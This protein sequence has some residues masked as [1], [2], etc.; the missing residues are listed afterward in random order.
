MIVS[1]TGRKSAALAKRDGS[2][3]EI[4]A[5]IASLS[6]LAE[7]DAFQADLDER[8]A[9]LPVSWNYPLLDALEAQRRYLMEA[10]YD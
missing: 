1:D 4:A 7:I 9:D 5:E 10:Y 2:W 8:S 3:D 6:S